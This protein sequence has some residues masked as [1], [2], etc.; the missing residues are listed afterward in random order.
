M[1]LRK[2]TDWHRMNP[3]NEWL[4]SS[5]YVS[6]RKYA[7]LLTELGASWDTF[8][9]RDPEAVANDLVTGGIPLLAARD[10]VELASVSAKQSY[11]PMA[12]FWDLE[13][14][15]RPATSS[16]RDV[17]TRLNSILK[18]YGD[19]VQF[20]GYASI[21]L[22]LIPQQKRSDLQLF[23]CPHNGRKEV[24]DKMIIDLH[25]AIQNTTGAT[26]CFVTGDVDYAYLLAVL[27]RYR[28]YRTIVIS[29]GTLQSC[30]M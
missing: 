22:K 3:F 17:S 29:K 16:G 1:E 10:N 30:W 15:P 2:T 5:Q 20:R 19:L 14:M 21:G 26:L 8:L 4:S 7:D 11:A 25:F 6:V 28:Q 12:V 9:S 23:D 18:P 27:Q 13:N 24:A